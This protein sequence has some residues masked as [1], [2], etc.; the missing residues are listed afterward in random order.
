MLDDE[1]R[2]QRLFGADQTT[3]LFVSLYLIL[4]A[5]FIVLGATSQ[6]ASDRA[7]AA[8]ESVNATFTGDTGL[9][10]DASG[11][12]DFR[13]YAGQ[14]AILEALRQNFYTQFEIQG[15]Y[16]TT[17]GAMIEFDLPSDYV[18]QPRSVQLTAR[19]RDFLQQVA[20]AGASDLDGR[21]LEA[22]FLMSD[23]VFDEVTVVNALELQRR[24]V[25]QLG[26][27]ANYLKEGDFPDAD[28][29]IGFYPVAANTL[30]IALRVSSQA[31]ASITLR[32][33]EV[34]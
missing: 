31:D 8:I 11:A 3:G 1:T 13:Q 28:L 23:P 30:R 17:G 15:R 10:S 5:F 22:S 20:T 32:R 4:L 26:H 16:S 27:I 9:A 2:G 34:N 7:K 6:R 18:F 24:R 25:R 29:S 14:D 33:P 12:E 21:R 19:A